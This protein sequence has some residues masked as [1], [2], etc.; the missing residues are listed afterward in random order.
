MENSSAC[1]ENWLGDKSP[2]PPQLAERNE[3]VLHL[4]E[5]LAKLPDDQRL[6]IEMKHLDGLPVAEI[7]QPDEPKRN[8]GYGPASAG[9]SQDA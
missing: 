2:S 5:A 9:R 7:S 8:F 3:R 6:A 4:A 1:L